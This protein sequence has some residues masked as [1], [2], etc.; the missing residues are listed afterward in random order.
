M[1]GG[2]ASRNRF[3][4]DFETLFAIRLLQSQALWFA[5]VDLAWMALSFL[6]A[7]GMLGAFTGG[8]TGLAAVCATVLGA[9]AVLQFWIKP[10]N[11]WA[12]CNALR[13]EFVKLRARALEYD[14]TRFARELRQLQS[15][16][17]VRVWNWLRLPTCNELCAELGC[18]ADIRHARPWSEQLLEKLP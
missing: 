3:E 7:A 1:R 12:A 14:D 5:R 8:Q 9:A 4:Y 10:R 11:N 18:V 2:I 13:G 6:A 15:S 17:G 16:E